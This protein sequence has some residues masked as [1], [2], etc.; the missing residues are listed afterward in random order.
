MPRIIS[1]YVAGNVRD[2]AA[3]ARAAARRGGG[4]TRTRL[5][6]LASR[7]DA[8]SGLWSRIQRAGSRAT[9]SDL[10]RAIALDQRIARS[11]H[12]RSQLT[13]RLVTAMVAEARRQRNPTRRCPLVRQVLSRNSGH[14]EARRMAAACESEASTLAN[15]A[16]GSERSNPQQ[17]Y[18]AYQSV[19]RM[20]PGNSPIAARAR[21]RIRALEPRISD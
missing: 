17:A 13:P 3:T 14:P 16:R 18:Q 4:A 8:F 7:I 9:R 2:A 15:R 19:L 21:E 11:N 10:E 5:N 6:G 1:A 12:Y 20:V